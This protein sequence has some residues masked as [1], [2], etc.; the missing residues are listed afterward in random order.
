MKK[1]QQPNLELLKQYSNPFYFNSK[2][3]N[4]KPKKTL[5]KDKFE[6]TTK[7]LFLWSITKFK[8]NKDYVIIDKEQYIKE[9]NIIDFKI[10][11]NA[12]L[13]LLKNSVIV[14]SIIENVYYVNFK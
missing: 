12:I 14:N 4:Y 3:I 11:D 10:V 8:N 2:F 1:N 6:T 9:H 13:E 7:E 5:L